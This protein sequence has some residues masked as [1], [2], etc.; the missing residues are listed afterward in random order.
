[1]KKTIIYASVLAILFSIVSC[2]NSDEKIRE[3]I[4]GSFRYTNTNE[5]DIFLISVEGIETFYEDGTVEDESILSIKF[6]KEGLGEASLTYRMDYTGEYMVENSHIIYDYSDIENTGIVELLSAESSSGSEVFVTEL[7]SQLESTLI[8]AFRER[9]IDE[10]A[11]E[12]Y[13]LNSEKLVI[14]NPEGE[15]IIKERMVGND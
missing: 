4:I 13:E 15:K 11:A 2:G 1:M 9:F 5:T 14:L 6:S 7:T 10:N 8:P 3:K 12:I